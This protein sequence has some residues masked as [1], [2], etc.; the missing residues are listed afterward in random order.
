MTIVCFISGSGTNYRE[1]VAKDPDHRYLV[2]TNRPG[3]EGLKIAK[4][5]KHETIELSHVP[6]LREARK[7]YPAGMIPRNCQER[8][9]FEQEAVRLIE[10]KLGGQP[11]LICM[12]GY[13]QWLTDW[14]V[15]RYFPRMINVHPGDTTRGYSGLHWIPTARAILAGEKELRSTVFIVDTGEDTGPVLVQSNPVDIQQALS[16]LEVRGTKGLLDRFE[17]IVSFSRTNN[18][19]SYESFIAAAGKELRDALE[20]VCTNLQEILK[21]SGDWKIYPFAV[22]DLIAQGRVEIDGRTIYVEGE[23]MPPYGYRKDEHRCQPDL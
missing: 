15:E 9:S 6:F 3:C 1:I 22:H 5:N 21:V 18:L 14:T 20:L 17:K 7:R 19:V 16:V 10:S 23:K 2:F 12:A 4:E 8:L 13:D 11:D